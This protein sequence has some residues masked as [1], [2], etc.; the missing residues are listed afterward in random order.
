M[1]RIKETF[2]NNRE[3]E[4]D[5]ETHYR[6]MMHA[7]Y[8]D[9]YEHRIERFKKVFSLMLDIAYKNGIT[10]DELLEAFKDVEENKER[11]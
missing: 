9:W 4:Y 8:Q 7:E 2:I 1:G 10:K 5:A 3:H 11:I 6:C